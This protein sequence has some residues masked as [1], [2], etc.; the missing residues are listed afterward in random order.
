MTQSVIPEEPILLSFIETENIIIIILE[1]KLQKHAT[2][3]IPRN[4]LK[5]KV[6]FL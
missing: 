4:K 1:E 3:S 2:C 6:T 5:N